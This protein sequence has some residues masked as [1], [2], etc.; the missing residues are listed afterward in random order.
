MRAFATAFVFVVAIVST[1]V[2]QT[3]SASERSAEVLFSASSFAVSKELGS[4]L[5]RVFTSNSDLTAEQTEEL[6]VRL[7]HIPDRVREAMEQRWTPRETPPLPPEVEARLNQ[8]M[9]AS[10]AGRRGEIGAA[11][12]PTRELIAADLMNRFDGEHLGEIAAFL[13][14]PAGIELTR[15]AAANVVRR[16]QTRVS[17]LPEEHRAAVEAFADTPSGRAYMRALQPLMQMI[18]EQL[19]LNTME[20]GRELMTEIAAVYCDVAPDC[21]SG[22]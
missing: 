16:Q 2:A 17:E 13:E 14:T 5:P 12:P 6:R 10:R 21:A 20:H 3:P 11:R 1:A 9:G 15:L 4:Q 22:M 8:M 18:V 19:R 7:E